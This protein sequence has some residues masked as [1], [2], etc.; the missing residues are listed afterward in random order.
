MPVYKDK[1]HDGKQVAKDHR[2]DIE[3]RVC[4]YCHL[5][6]EEYRNTRQPC[7]RI[8]EDAEEEEWPQRSDL[9]QESNLT[10]GTKQYNPV[11]NVIYQNFANTK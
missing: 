11:P 8:T 3:T 9:Q 6:M 7:K 4:V 1:T 10:Y 5:P 2:F